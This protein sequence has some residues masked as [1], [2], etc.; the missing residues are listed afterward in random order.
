MVDYISPKVTKKQTR[1]RGPL[2]S[3]Q[4]SFRASK[5]AIYRF[6]PKVCKTI[7]D[8]CKQE[9]PK[10]HKTPKEWKTVGKVFAKTWNYHNCGGVLDGKHVPIKKPKKGGSLYYKK[11]HSFILVDVID[12][13]HTFLTVDIG[14][15]RGAADGGTRVKCNIHHAIEQNQVGFL[16]VSALLKDD[17]PTPST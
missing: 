6:V 3:L 9:V 1:M 11:F 5:S 2:T 17:T 16:E 7:I 14:D 4:Y 10:H 8:T 15:K 13:K 12:V